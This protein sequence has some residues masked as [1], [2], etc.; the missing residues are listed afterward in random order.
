MRII[1]TDHLHPHLAE[2]L[3]AA[4]FSVDV[5]PEITN[6]EVSDVIENYDGLVLST[7]ILVTQTLIDKAS[8]LKFIARA[9]SGMENIDV[10]YAQLKNIQV[11]NSPE[12]NAN[13]VAEHALGMLLSLLNNISAAHYE[14]KNDIWQ[15][16]KN[17]G[18]ELD[19][20]TIGIIGYGNTGSAFAKK[21]AG[22]HVKILAHDKYKTGFGNERVTE[23][24]L[25]KI[26]L[27]ADIISLHI[28]HTT[29]THHY[30]NETFITECKKEFYLLNT[31]RGRNVRTKDLLEAL[32]N[33]K[34]KGA[35]LDVFEN[36]KFYELPPEDKEMLKKLAAM[37][38]VI[39]TPHIAG[40][41]HESFFKI[42]DILL[43]RIL[44]LYLV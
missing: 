25:E 7:K 11:L 16:E 21:L 6:V 14:I 3:T 44:A 42:S 43:Q 19:G 27:E 30:I 29:E 37:N 31:S 20:K 13:A 41:T 2:Q 10:K 33:G 26:K 28:P 22:F 1:I 12:G 39:L 35:A 9:G 17:R 5:F 15:R 34:I 18:V 8:R 24:Y 23:S 4:G 36:E 38:N 32:Q 40:W